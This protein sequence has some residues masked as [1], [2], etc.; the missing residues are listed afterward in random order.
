MT[1]QEKDF[2]SKPFKFS[3]SSLNKLLF[4]PSLFY[5]DYILKQRQEKLD[6]H[7]LEGKVLHCLLFE[8]EK[9]QEKFKIVPGKLPTDN[10]RKILHSLHKVSNLGLT[11]D[12][13][14]TDLMSKELENSILSIL[15]EENLYQT[16]KED[17]ARLV[18]IQCQENVE[19]WNFINNSKVDVVDEETLKRC[20]EQIEIIKNNTEVNKIFGEFQTDFPLD[21]IETFSEKYLECKLDNY[22]FGLKG[23]VDFYKIDNDKKEIVICDLKTTSKTIDEFPETVDY[24][25]YWLQAVI[26]TK[27]VIENLPEEKQNYKIIFTFIVID[28]YNQVYP[29]EVSE[30]SLDAWVNDLRYALQTA[31]YHYTNNNYSLPFKYLVNKVR[32]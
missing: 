12:N 2:Y 18:K 1:E 4:S 20:Q 22:N 31:D 30:V 26:Y 13:S 14:F 8:P 28:K 9:L 21:T 17:S 11:T 25:K 3:Y 6:K 16:L 32:L 15:K 24:Y 29:F 27:L 5:N 23:Y 10:V 19:Y 7:L